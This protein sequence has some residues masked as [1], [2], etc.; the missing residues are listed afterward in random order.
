MRPGPTELTIE[1]STEI[2]T[3]YDFEGVGVGDVCAAQQ[4]T[5]VHE[6]TVSFST[7]GT[8]EVVFRVRDSELDLEVVEIVRTV[9]VN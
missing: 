8:G 6:T 9:E 3:P 7:P 5:F 4:V 2:I 1:G